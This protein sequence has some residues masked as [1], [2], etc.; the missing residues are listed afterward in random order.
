MRY[1]LL[2]LLLISK[3][4]SAQLPAFPD[5]LKNTLPATLQEGDS[6][7]IVEAFKIYESKPAVPHKPAITE[8]TEKNRRAQTLV[9]RYRISRQKDAYTFTVYKQQVKKFPNKTIKHI[10]AKNPFY[11]WEVEQTRTLTADEVLQLA[12]YCRTQLEPNKPVTVDDRN[13]KLTILMKNRER[14][15]VTKPKEPLYF[16]FVRKAAGY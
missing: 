10:S 1:A 13:P 6:L 11:T 9:I 2:L 3:T 12:I 15:Q 4:A 5:S 7:V 16:N 8:L 14:R